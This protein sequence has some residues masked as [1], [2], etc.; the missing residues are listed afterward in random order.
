M[1]SSLSINNTQSN[2]EASRGTTTRLAHL[3]FR[4][5]PPLPEDPRE[6]AQ[7]LENFFGPVPLQ[8]PVRPFAEQLGMGIEA[9]QRGPD[10]RNP[11]FSPVF[12]NGSFKL[13]TRDPMHPRS[14]FRLTC[15]TG[16]NRDQ[17]TQ[18]TWRFRL[19]HQDDQLGL[20]RGWTV[21]PWINWAELE[22]GV[23]LAQGRMAIL[24]EARFHSPRVPLAPRRQEV[25]PA[26]T[27]PDCPCPL[28]VSYFNFRYVLILTLCL[29][30]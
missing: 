11:H 28:P 12:I 20:H 3:F 27:I 24:T 9:V 10:L 6:R 15:L 21:G 5:F 25:W 19:C 1:S 16:S 4:I 2:S 17:F 26:T 14:S 22:N 29:Q 7:M 30:F 23:N 13:V 18:Q 8:I